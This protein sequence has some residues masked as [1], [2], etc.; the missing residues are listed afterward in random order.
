MKNIILMSLIGI[1]GSISAQN[2][3]CG[4]CQYNGC[5]TND[6]VVQ[7]GCGNGDNV[8]TENCKASDQNCY[9]QKAKAERQLKKSQAIIPEHVED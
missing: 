6:C 5:T 9:D 4:T 8:S 2:N 1:C 3:F 7:C